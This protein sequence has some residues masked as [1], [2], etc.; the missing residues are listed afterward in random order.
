[1]KRGFPSID[2]DTAATQTFVISLAH[3]RRIGTDQVDVSAGFKPG[4]LNDGGFATNCRTN[5]IGPSRGGFDF[6]HRT[7]VDLWKLVAKVRA[8]CC[9]LIMRSVP[10]KYLS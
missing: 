6:I 3:G 10:D 7:E 9:G 8:Q 4:A 1:M 2:E 5:Q